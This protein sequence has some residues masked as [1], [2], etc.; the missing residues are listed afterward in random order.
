M[1]V[2]DEQGRRT[3]FLGIAED[4]TEHKRAE[5]QLARAEQRYHEL[6]DNLR[7]GV[8]RNTP[9]EQGR[10]V[11]ANPALVAMFEADSREELLR[12]SVSDL[13]VNPAQRKEFSESLNRHGFVHDEELELKTLRGRQFWASVTATME[14]GR[15]R[16]RPSSTASSWT[17]PS[18]TS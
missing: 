8:Y 7:V 3:H 2:L 4:V 11:E 9:G 13:Y 15:G 1:S 14:T 17:S 18:A 6:V 12:H 10:F 16:E 5:E